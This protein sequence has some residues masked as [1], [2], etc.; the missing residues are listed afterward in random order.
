VEAGAVLETKYTL[1]V[2]GFVKEGGRS[3]GDGEFEIF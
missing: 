2:C 3:V 1:G